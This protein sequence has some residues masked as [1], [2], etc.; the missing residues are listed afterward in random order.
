MLRRVLSK[1]HRE[2]PESEE[3][4]ETVFYCS[5]EDDVL[6][7]L[8]GYCGKSGPQVGLDP[9]DLMEELDPG[10]PQ[11]IIRLHCPDGSVDSVSIHTL[12]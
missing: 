3:I 10:R 11:R 7:L 1:R 5:T 12:H 6:N 8:S 2:S 9:Y 4:Q